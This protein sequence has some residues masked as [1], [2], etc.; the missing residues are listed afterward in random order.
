MS[1]AHSR[2]PKYNVL[3]K[4]DSKTRTYFPIILSYKGKV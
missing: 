2:V 4:L 3:E 1:S